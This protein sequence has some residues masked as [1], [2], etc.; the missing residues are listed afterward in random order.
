MNSG[1]DQD[2]SLASRSLMDLFVEQFEEENSSVNTF[3]NLLTFLKAVFKYAK[4]ENFIPQDPTE[5]LSKR[6]TEK[7]IVQLFYS[8]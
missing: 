8:K 7:K 1:L 5:H 6:T 3:N 4:R 2:V